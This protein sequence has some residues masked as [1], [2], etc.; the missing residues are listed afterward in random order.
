MPPSNEK[1]QTIF[2]S[3]VSAPSLKV[4]HWQYKYLYSLLFQH[5][6]LIEKLVL[7]KKWIFWLQSVIWEPNGW[8][9]VE[10]SSENK[11]SLDFLCEL[12]NWHIHSEEK[13]YW[14][15]CIISIIEQ[16]YKLSSSFKKICLRC[17]PSLSYVYECIFVPQKIK[18]IISHCFLPSHKRP[19]RLKR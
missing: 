2:F 16:F 6:S 9:C 7:F 12:I 3:H 11:S 4:S 19:E 5:Y 15:Y 17:D 1:A 13:Q 8:I 14:A 10:S 18:Q